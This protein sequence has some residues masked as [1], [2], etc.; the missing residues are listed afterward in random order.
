MFLISKEIVR[1]SCSLNEVLW[2]N[3]SIMV[4]QV[5]I[6]SLYFENIGASVIYQLFLNGCEQLTKAEVKV[7]NTIY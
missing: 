5:F 3:D 7:I 1:R 2:K 6:I 4:D